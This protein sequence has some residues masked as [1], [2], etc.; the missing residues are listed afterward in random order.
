MKVYFSKRHEEA[1]CDGKLNVSFPLQCR[2]S[3]KRILENY[4]DWEE[5]DPNY[6]QNVTFDA[7]EEELKTFYGMEELK[8]FDEKSQRVPASLPQVIL[9]GL[10]YEV[11][12]IIE[13]W[14]YQK[15]SKGREC[16]KELNEILAIHNSPWRIVNGEAIRI[17]SEYLHQEVRAKTINLLT[18]YEAFGALEEYQDAISDLMS[19]E[20]KDAVHKAHKSVESVMKTVLETKEPLRFGQLLRKLIDSNI[21][22]E[23]Y[24][25][26]MKN[27]EQLVVGVGKERN[28]PGR[29]H[30]Q[31]SEATTVPHCLAELAVNLAGS[32]NVFIIKHWMEKQK[33]RS[34]AL[35]TIPD[36]PF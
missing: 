15:P 29:G 9:K 24:D 11:L 27:F 26:F 19:G 28:L 1:I 7:V 34:D 2:T 36:L 22:P 16:E 13:A 35:D 10:P 5:Y 12:D 25:G 30:G 18:T 14:F 6:P 21:I 31:G 32:I 20:T 4:S 8:S 3:I 33:T 17:D 23:Y